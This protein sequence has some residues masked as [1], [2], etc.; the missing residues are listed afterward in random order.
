MEDFILSSEKV[1]SMRKT[2]DM[3]RYFRQQIDN[4]FRA[5]GV[6]AIFRAFEAD[7]KINGDFETAVTEYEPF[8]V[9][10]LADEPYL[11]HGSIKPMIKT[12]ALL[13]RYLKSK[14]ERFTSRVSD[15][16]AII[17][18]QEKYKEMVKYIDEATS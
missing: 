17:S 3:V 14:M 8:F 18:A 16:P 1:Q 5:E 15:I 2:R 12:K 13:K 11:I 10:T 6:K 4:I 7:D 9:A